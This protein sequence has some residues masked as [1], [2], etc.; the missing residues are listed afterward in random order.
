MAVFRKPPTCPFCGEVIAIA[1]TK[2]L[3]NQIIGDNFSHW[4]YIK[5]ECQEEKEFKMKHKWQF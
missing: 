4:E 5:H 2:N 3:K 1:R